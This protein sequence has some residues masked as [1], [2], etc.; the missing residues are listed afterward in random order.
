MSDKAPGLAN[1]PVGVFK[2]HG[3]EIPA[4]VA[5]FWSESRDKWEVPYVEAARV[6]DAQPTAHEISKRQEEEGH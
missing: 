6:F 1:I 2:K 5:E 3:I 4:P